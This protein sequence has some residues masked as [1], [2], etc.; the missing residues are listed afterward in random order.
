[1]LKFGI[2]IAKRSIF[3]A[4][5]S[6]R[7]GEEADSTIWSVGR[8]FP[9]KGKWFIISR[10]EKENPNKKESRLARVLANERDQ[11][12]V[13]SYVQSLMKED[14][15]AH[16]SVDLRSGKEI[17][18]PYSSGKDLS[19]SL[20]AYVED[21][22]RY[23]KISDEVAVDFL[24][25]QTDPSLENCI[26]QEFEANYHFEFDEKRTESRRTTLLSVILVVI[27][28]VFLVLSSL[29]GYFANDDIL[30]N[31]LSQVASIVSWVFIWTGAEKFFFDRAASNKA[32][33]RAAQLADATISFIIEP[34]GKGL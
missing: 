12:Y 26:R 4:V 18:E 11:H 29:L 15:K 25:E 21:V 10:M 20:F 19:R 31:I 17:F 9:D 8:D 1:L 24:L 33:L 28:V 34:S 14:G 13:G 5:F 32:A 23:L 3:E 2:E 30:L 6:P 7:P 22:A 27:G 16:I